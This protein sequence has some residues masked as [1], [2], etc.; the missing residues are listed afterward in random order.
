MKNSVNILIILLTIIALLVLH[1]NANAVSWHDDFE[2]ELADSWQLQGSDSI[3]QNQQGFLRA[4]IDTQKQWQT[5]FELYQFIA[6]PGPYNNITIDIENIGASGENRIGIAL[7]NHFLNDA[8][9]VEETG[10][11]LFFT[12]DM[13]ASRNGKV[14]LGPGR[15]WPTDVLK[16]MVIQFDS[17]RFQLFGDGASRL[18]F[19]DA[20]LSTID[21]IGF[22]FVAY[23]TDREI[24]DD[25][26]V[27]KITISGLAVSPKNKITTIWGNLKQE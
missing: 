26:W 10:Y 12:N 21:I 5:L 27:E 7:G 18:D 6:F 16:E 14:F 22:V 3:W 4:K 25:A 13:Q 11:Y 19:I 8:G 24:T 9:E 15:R 2:I 1:G 23:V 17:G 20:N